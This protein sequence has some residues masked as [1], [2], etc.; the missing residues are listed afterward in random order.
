MKVERYLVHLAFKVEH[1]LRLAQSDKG[2][3]PIHF[4]DVEMIYAGHS[5]EL[6]GQIARVRLG[7]RQYDPISKLGFED[8]GK[9]L[10]DHDL[11]LTAFEIGA[12]HEYVVDL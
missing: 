10:P 8:F 6:L 7:H 5:E 2:H 11:S 3:R 1:L 9:P 12:L 4:L